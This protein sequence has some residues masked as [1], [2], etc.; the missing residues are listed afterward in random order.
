MVGLSISRNMIGNMI[1]FMITG[2][3]IV[4]TAGCHSEQAHGR[5]VEPTQGVVVDR[6]AVDAAITG[7]DPRLGLDLLGGEDTAYRREQRIAVE[8]LE[9]PRQLLNTVDLAAPLHL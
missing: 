3:A 9:V 2:G 6:H 5:V 7:E 8:Q 1:T 4:A